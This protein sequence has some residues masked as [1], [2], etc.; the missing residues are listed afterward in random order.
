MYFSQIIFNNWSLF[1]K[2][3]DSLIF[4]AVLIEGLILLMSQYN[5]LIFENVKIGARRVD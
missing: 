4:C 5:I 2:N 3:N 1:Q